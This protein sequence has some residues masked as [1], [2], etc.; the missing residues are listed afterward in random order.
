MIAYICDRCKER[1]SMKQIEQHVFD[2]VTLHLCKECSFRVAMQIAWFKGEPLESTPSE[3]GLY[4]K[5][6]EVIR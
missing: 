2:G 6:A 5:K 1:I 4:C 3:K